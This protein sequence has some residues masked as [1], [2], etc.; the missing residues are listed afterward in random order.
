[1]FWG[2]KVEN[3]KG[4]GKVINTDI[5]IMYGFIFKLSYSKGSDR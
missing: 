2:G 4:W 1:M 5:Y 3:K